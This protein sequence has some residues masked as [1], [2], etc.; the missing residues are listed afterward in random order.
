MVSSKQRL[1]RQFGKA[2]AK[3]DDAAQVQLDIAFDLLQKVPAQ[4]GTCLDLGC[5]TGRLTYRLQPRCQ[6]LIGIDLAHP[7]LLQ[8]RQNRQDICWLNGDADQ[9]PCADASFDT[10][11]SSMALQWCNPIDQ[12]M[13]EAYRVLKPGGKAFI[14]LL[15]Q[16]ALVELQNSWLS[17]DSNPRV[18]TF[19]SA[20]QLHDAAI[21]AGFSAR[22][23]QKNYVTWHADVR[24]LLNSIR[25]IGA[26]VVPSTG[27]RKPLNRDSLRQLQA[28]YSQS[29]QRN[30]QLPLSYLVSFLELSK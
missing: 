15:S 26:N 5:G 27:N 29:Y 13:M 21:S 19:Q 25:H 7:M 30:K 3:Y 12:A 20:Q 1:A 24:S 10:I 18:N 22:S 8:A 6:Q 16:G 23:E 9:L 14:A 28:S 2:A 4:L 17:I 11:V